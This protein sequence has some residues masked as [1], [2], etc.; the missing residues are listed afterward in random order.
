MRIDGLTL[1]LRILLISLLLL[2][3]AMSWTTMRSRGDKAVAAV[4]P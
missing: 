1:R 2:P 4:W 3:S